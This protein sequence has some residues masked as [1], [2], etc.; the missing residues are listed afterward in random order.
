MQYI[1][2]RELSVALGLN[3]RALARWPREY[4]PH[5]TAN[6]DYRFSD[7]NEWLAEPGRAH[8]FTV[9]PTIEKIL[10][11]SVKF[12]PFKQVVQMLR[13]VVDHSDLV[14]YT[15]RRVRNGRLK[16]LHLRR[17]LWVVS[18]ASVESLIREHKRLAEDFTPAQI[19]QIFGVGLTASSPARASAI[20]HRLLQ[21]GKLVALQD[22]DNA[23]KVRVTRESAVSLLTELLAS[24]PAPMDAED[25]IEDRLQ[26][27]HPLLTVRQTAERLGLAEEEVRALLLAGK[28]HYIPSPERGKWL[29]LP[30]SVALYQQNARPLTNQEVG[31][32]FGVTAKTVQGWRPKGLLVCP[33]HGVAC[34][35]YRWCMVA[36][37]QQRASPGIQAVA[38]VRQRLRPSGKVVWQENTILGRR[39]LTRKQ[40]ETGVAEGR[41]DIVRTPRNLP[42]YVAHQIRQ[43]M[44]RYG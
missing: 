5:P 22:T 8:G 27:P 25:W 12:I 30:E 38:W 44:E 36:Y 18:V 3:P 1:T 28:M 32:I 10:G 2:T 13:G 40:L 6:G 41:L 17:Y 31:R 42:V 34:P 43:E 4:K 7:V 33:L 19:N 37:V 11:G 29:V 39:L 26:S 24:V 9:V 20:F 35:M 21:H 16:A 23:R 14:S 15:I